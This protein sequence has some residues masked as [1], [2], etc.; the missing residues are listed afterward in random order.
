MIS[1]SNR[2]MALVFVIFRR[3]A[4]AFADYS[5]DDASAMQIWRTAPSIYKVRAVE[6]H[7][8]G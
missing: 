7:L 8:P 1:Q 6:L 2:S 4:R 5:C 3:D